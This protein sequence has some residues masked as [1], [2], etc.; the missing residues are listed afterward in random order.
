MASARRRKPNGA[1]SPVF[2]Q[3]PSGTHRTKNTQNG[4]GGKSAMIKYTRKVRIEPTQNTVNQDAV[5]AHLF[6]RCF[7]KFKLAKTSQAP[8]RYAQN[9]SI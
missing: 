8:F 9:V 7:S 1:K 6:K 3:K 4:A 2:S 5:D